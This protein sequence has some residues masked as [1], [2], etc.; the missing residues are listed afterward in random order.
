MKE[1]FN[2]DFWLEDRGWY[3][4]GLDADKQPIDTLASNMGHCL[5]T[6]IVDVEKAAT[7]A[8]RLMSPDIRSGWGLRTLGTSMA[9]YNPVSYHSGSV[10]PHDTALSAAG[11]VRY[12]FI[13][14]AHR[15]IEGLLDVASA[16]GGRLPELF[17]GFS[18]DEVPQPVA[19]PTSCVPQA[20][21]AATPLL[22]LRLL[23][24]FDPGASEQRL[25]LAPALPP[26][27][28][29]LRVA[30]IHVGGR[31]L[32]VSADGDRCDVDGASGLLVSSSP[33]P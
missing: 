13:E 4:L 8:D 3:A 9:A 30:G 5:W 10:W 2:R 33:R 18:R 27:I 28:R 1:D 7:V 23:L 14:E 16:M 15:L 32:T 26:S 17:A 22:L 11:L 12:G 6:G 21:A 31:E 19:Y 29:H 20:W 24:R 25:W